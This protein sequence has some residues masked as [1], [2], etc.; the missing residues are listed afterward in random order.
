MATITI[1]GNTNDTNL[2]LS[3]DNASVTE[4]GGSTGS[5][6]VAGPA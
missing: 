1:N 3:S 4:N 6:G 2:V 5:A